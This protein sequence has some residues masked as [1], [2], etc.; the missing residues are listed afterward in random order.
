[1][2][3]FI[4]L[5]FYAVCVLAAAFLMHNLNA[6]YIEPNYL[7]FEDPTT[8]YSKLPKLQNAMLSW[9]WKLSGLGHFFTSLAVVA[10]AFVADE[11]F[12]KAFPRVG[13]LALGAG[14]L[15]GCGFMLI[16]VTH[17]GGSQVLTLLS[18]QNPE[19][20]DNVFLISTITRVSFNSLAIVALG[21]FIML[22][23]WCGMQSGRIGKAFGRYGYLAGAVGFMMAFVYA[24][25]YLPFYL[26]WAV[27]AAV[28]FRNMGSKT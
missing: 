25:A 2:D 22:F 15:A 19:F 23:S 18:E 1:M 9:P 27:W 24:P 11:L 12:S 20:R 8:D 13:K 28:A 6:W 4:R 7:G 10:L 16:G 21:W 14:L 5:G 3:Q 17:V 26:I